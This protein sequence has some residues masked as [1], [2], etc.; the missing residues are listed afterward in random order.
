MAEW[1]RR[2]IRNLLGLARAGSSP[3]SYESEYVGELAQLVER[4]LS[5]HEVAGSIPAF[6]TKFVQLK[7]KVNVVI[8]IIC[9]I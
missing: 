7:T 9:E 3:V 5:M 6:S 4:V 1:L 8:W 2:E